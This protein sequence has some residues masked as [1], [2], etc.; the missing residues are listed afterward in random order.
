MKGRRAIPGISPHR[1]DEIRTQAQ[2]ELNKL[3]EMRDNFQLQTD[4]PEA[5]VR[6]GPV[7]AIQSLFHFK[8]EHIEEIPS[9]NA[10]FEIAGII[11]RHVK[12]ITIAR[13]FPLPSRRFTLAHELGHLVL[14]PGR[15]YH[16]DRPING[17][18]HLDRRRSTVE[19]EADLFGAEFLMPTKLLTKVFIT[20][21]GGRMNGSDADDNIC[22]YLSQATC[23]RITPRDYR[24]MRV[25]DRAK[26]FAEISNFGAT[27]FSPL[28][29]RF[30]V[31]K[32][33]MAIQLQDIGLVT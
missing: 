21:F 11:D 16:R 17:G 7:A 13:K 25:L 22:Y 27:C 4:D 12:Q 8:V 2:R 18:E 33:A 5:L 20:S 10:G 15:V 6:I 1:E 31:S 29:E 14:H 3:W 24:A 28:I 30:R 26:I 23:R 9:D 32:V 19:R